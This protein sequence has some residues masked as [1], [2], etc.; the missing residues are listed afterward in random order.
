MNKNK[1]EKK[2]L[3][4]IYPLPERSRFI[5]KKK[6]T[7]KLKFNFIRNDSVKQKKKLN[8]LTSGLRSKPF[9]LTFSNICTK[10]VSFKAFVSPLSN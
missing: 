4:T 1:K 6:N 2:K 10:F 7:K 5:G 9:I 3:K 8:K